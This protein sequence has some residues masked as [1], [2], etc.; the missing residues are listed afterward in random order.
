MPEIE[1]LGTANETETPSDA[2]PRIEPPK[3]LLTEPDMSLPL[4][5]FQSVGAGDT[6]D[7]EDEEVSIFILCWEYLH[8]LL[9]K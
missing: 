5:P 3:D 2:I 6:F 1:D 4:D 9:P 7:D 8:K